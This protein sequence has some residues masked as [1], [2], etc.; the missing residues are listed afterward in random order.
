MLRFGA[1]ANFIQGTCA[2]IS[3]G[4]FLCESGLRVSAYHFLD[5]T[6]RN[7][8]AACEG[9]QRNT[10]HCIPHFAA[11]ALLPRGGGKGRG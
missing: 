6:P 10:G 5:K 9:K 7:H 11:Q 8:I 3:V 4:Y 2:F 1:V